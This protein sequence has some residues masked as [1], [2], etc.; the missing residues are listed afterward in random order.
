M[1]V[2][3]FA[4]G[5]MALSAALAL[6]TYWSARHY[7]VDQRE[8]TALRQSFANASYVRDNLQTAGAPVPEALGALTPAIG[9][10][11]L[12]ERRGEWYSS[13]LEFSSDELPSQVV[14]VV[15]DGSASIGW[16]RAS[17]EPALVVGVPLG[18]VGAT[19]Y[20]VSPTT[21]LNDTLNTL[22][23]ILVL[24]AVGT[25]VAGAVLGWFAARKVL[26]PLQR[27]TSAAT[28]I[29]AGELD[30]RLSPSED[31]DLTALVGAFNHMVDELEERIQRESRFVADVSHE[32][33]SPMTTFATGVSLLASDTSVTGRPREAV[34]LLQR[35]LDRF[36]RSLDEL[37]ELSKL[38]AGVD[39]GAQTVVD[40]E[41]LVKESLHARRVERTGHSVRVEA[42]V[43]ALLVRVDK[44]RVARA[45]INLFDNADLHGHGLT[46]VWIARVDDFGDVHVVDRGPG[47]AASDRLR[48][49]ERFAR[50]G[51]RGSRSGA[52]LG[53]SIVAETA[54][55]AG[56]AA[57]CVC[58]P[59]QGGHFV[60]RLPLEI[61]D[62]DGEGL[63]P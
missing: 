33:K 11:T 27:V 46:Q 26:M 19:Y 62:D 15:E 8:R 35:E 50:A 55:L 1:I 7:L 59:H 52:G 51:S 5:S 31:R 24:S 56:G 23:V 39:E 20:E 48:V 58:G 2:L 4:L 44:R 28:Q 30:T 43:E 41:D 37:L 60:F 63:I 38:D 49:F 32:L 10:V 40:L 57:W 22:R 61:G 45:L 18:E 3:A 6:G 13:S 16:A 42:P 17:G 12:V 36:Q 54:R 29:S 53:L 34:D 9:T 21:E 14:D 25:T 47:V